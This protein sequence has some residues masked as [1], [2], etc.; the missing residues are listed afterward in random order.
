MVA[1]DYKD[2]KKEVKEVKKVRPEKKMKTF[3][4]TSLGL[5]IKACC[6]KEALKIIEEMGLQAPEKK[7]ECCN[8]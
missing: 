7:Q 3:A 2:K 4:F 6:Y 1:K 8:D 5:T